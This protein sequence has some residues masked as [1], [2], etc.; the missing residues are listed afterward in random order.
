MSAAVIGEVI[1]RKAL[2]ICLS[3]CN[4]ELIGISAVACLHSARGNIYALDEF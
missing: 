4:S 2:L 1:N 3:Q